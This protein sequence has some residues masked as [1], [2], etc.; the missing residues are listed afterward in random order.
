MDRLPRAG[1][2]R[3]D[4]ARRPRIQPR[5]G[6][7]CLSN[8]IAPFMRSPFLS[9]LARWRPFFL[10]ALALVG[11]DA[12]RLDAIVPGQSTTADVIRHWGEPPGRWDND[13][14]SVTWEYPRGPMGTATYLITL[15]ADGVV[16]RVEQALTEANYARIR[17]GMSHDEVRRI[18]GSPGSTTVFPLK[19]EEV[20]DWRIAGNLQWEEW[21]LYVNFGLDGRVRS[22]SKAMIQKG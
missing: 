1:E 19:Q 21:H 22:T 12:A 6:R 13:D 20:W 3:Y 8:E 4:V 2:C 5:T 15:G 14:G 17:P 9:W 7:H 18:L 16:R 10:G 11:C